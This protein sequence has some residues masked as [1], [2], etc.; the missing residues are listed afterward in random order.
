LQAAEKLPL[1]CYCFMD[2]GTL[3]DQKHPAIQFFTK[4]ATATLLQE[5]AKR[6]NTYSMGLLKASN[7]CD[8]GSIS[9]LEDRHWLFDFRVDFLH[10]TVGDY[11]RT[12]TMRI[13]LKSWSSESFDVD[14][15]ICKASIATLRLTPSTSVMFIEASR[16]LS[17]LHVFMSHVRYLPM[18]T[19][20]LFVDSCIASL[21]AHNEELSDISA[22]ILGSGNYWA[23]DSSFDFAILYH[24]VSYG[25]GE[26]VCMQLDSK[27]L[28]FFD[29]AS[30]LLSGC[31]SW[32]SRVRR[33]RFELDFNTAELLLRK[34]LNP[35]VPWGDRSFSF[36][37]SLLTTTYSN[38]LKGGLTQRDYDAIKSALQHGADGKASVEVFSGRRLADTNAVEILEIVLPKKQFSAI[39][40]L[41]K[42]KI[43][44]GDVIDHGYG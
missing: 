5:T 29:P 41:E 40:L 42:A 30:A 39:G 22:M 2:K 33:G 14:P 18:G 28:Q 4:E 26:Y 27:K 38:H 11:L 8:D 7:I 24:C 17:I 43:P 21:R 3:I 15:E 16:A 32:D 6:L 31:F 36:W 12:A 1:M 9:D 37:R 34:G 20:S 44:G 23:Y 13:L 25:I 19:Q 35:N 10:R